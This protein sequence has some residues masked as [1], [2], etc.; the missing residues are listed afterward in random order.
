MIYQIQSGD[1]LS[2]IALR[3]TGDM[4]R[5]PEILELN[6]QITNPDLIK[7]GDLLT[8]PDSWTDYGPP[9]PPPYGPPAPLPVSP[10]GPGTTGGFLTNKTMLIGAGI[11]LVAVVAYYFWS[12]TKEAPVQEGAEVGA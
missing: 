10:V 4:Y 6:P 3:Y 7:V 9:A 1:S 8:L 2:K 12:Q 5:Y 11:V